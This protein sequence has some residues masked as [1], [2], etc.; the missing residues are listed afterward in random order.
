MNTAHLI[1]AAR[2]AL[3]ARR[4]HEQGV[5]TL[6]VTT[7]RDSDLHMLTYDSEN[8]AVRHDDGTLTYVDLTNTEFAEDLVAYAEDRLATSGSLGPLTLRLGSVT[9]TRPP[10]ELNART[11]LF[12]LSIHAR[13]A[14]HHPGLSGNRVLELANLAYETNDIARHDTTRSLAQIDP[15]VREAAAR[16]LPCP[17]EANAEFLIQTARSAV[18]TMSHNMQPCP[19]AIELPAGHFGDIPAWLA[20]QA[21]ARFRD[22]PTSHEPRY[23]TPALRAVLQALAALQTPAEGEWLRLYLTYPPANPTGHVLNR[24]P[25]PEGA[26]VY[27]AMPGAVITDAQIRHSSDLLEVDQYVLQ[28]RS[29]GAWRLPHHDQPAILTNRQVSAIL[30]RARARSAPGAIRLSREAD[31]TVYMSDTAQAAR[32][33]PTRLIPN[34]RDGRCPGCHTPYATAGDGPCGLAA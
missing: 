19:L 23:D 18:H 7:T 4:A 16:E 11:R 21:V 6:T 14:A 2:D 26:S 20:H 31:G 34:H 28:L 32:Y 30:R 13:A 10:A 25:I 12:I 15:Y 27:E 24:D 22:S 29:A 1:T 5:N 9:V 33:L 17:S 8:V 3:A